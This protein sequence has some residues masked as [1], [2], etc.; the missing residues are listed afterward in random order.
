VPAHSVTAA[1]ATS[2]RLLVLVTV[3][4]LLDTPLPRY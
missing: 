2:L 4:R 1:V 3:D